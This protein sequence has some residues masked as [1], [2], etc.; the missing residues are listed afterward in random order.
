MGALQ[1]VGPE[2]RIV[3]AY[4]EH[5]H[6]LVRGVTPAAVMAEMFGK[7][8]GC[9][10][11]RGE[12]MHLFDAGRR[13][14]GGTAIVVG[15]MP[16]AVGLALADRPQHAPHVTCCL[17]GDG[18]VAEGEFHEFADRDVPGYFQSLEHLL[19]PCARPAFALD[20][21]S[22]VPG[23]GNSP[24]RAR[25]TLPRHKRGNWVGPGRT[26]KSTRPG[27]SGVIELTPFE[28]LDRPAAV[29]PPP[30]RHR[31]RYHGV[32]P[33]NHPLRQAVTALAIGNLGK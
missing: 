20:R 6:A 12:S 17:F 19:R 26:E 33:P 2:D 31:H 14:Y 8:T 24:E 16:M 32:F 28:F 4:R 1:G 25:Y 10:R 3:A 29:I 27:A 18:A 30:Q 15:G 11:G 22:V 23:T 7:V 9:C 5:A 21:L 13:F